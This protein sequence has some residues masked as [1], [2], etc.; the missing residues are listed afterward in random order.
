MKSKCILLLALAGLFLPQFLYSQIW[1]GSL[2]MHYNPSFAGSSD[3]IRISTYNSYQR[4]NP[5]QDY[6]EGI[7]GLQAISGDMFIS[8]ISTG[9]GLNFSYYSPSQMVFFVPT[10]SHLFNAELVV[11]PKI[12]IKGKFTI[13]PSISLSYYKNSYNY[14]NSWLADG[15][16]PDSKIDYRLGILVNNKRFFAGVA[17]ELGPLV[18]KVDNFKATSQVLV[19][20]SYS[21]LHAGYAFKL[22]K[23]DNLSLTPQVVLDIFGSK[24]YITDFIPTANIMMRYKKLITGVGYAQNPQVMAGLQ[25]KAFRLMVIKDIVTNSTDTRNPKPNHVALSMRYLIG[26]K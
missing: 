9:I 2:P 26:K 21:I 15:N 6:S 7:R 22:D 3:E 1:L 14:T 13:S 20:S 17:M 11:A 24:Y 19:T 23:D 16:R 10:V 5:E 8:K 12:S 25:T 4:V 18:E